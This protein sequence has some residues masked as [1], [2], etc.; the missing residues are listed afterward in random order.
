MIPIPRLLAA[1]LL[2]LLVAA[3][4]HAQ[5]TTPFD[6]ERE[7][8]RIA[9]STALW[10]GF[11][12][13]AI[14]L[15]VYDGERTLFFR[16]PSPP[17]GSVP[18]P[19]TDAVALSSRHPAVTA[20]SS[21]EIGGVVTATLLADGPRAAGGATAL[22]ATALH[23]AFHVF[24]RRRHPS[25]IANEGDL[26]LYP[27]DDPVPLAERRL[28]S[29]ALA[30]ALGAGDGAVAACWAREALAHRAARFAAMDSAFARYDRASELNEGL[31]AWI[32]LRAE[33][34]ATVAIPAAELPAA[35]V[36]DRAY[37][38]GP[39]LAFLLAR[40]EPAWRDSLEAD[41]RRSLDGMLAE[42]LARLSARRPCG[43]ATSEVAEI[44]RVADADARAVTDERGARRAAFD[45][46]PGPRLV[47]EAAQGR[48]LWPQ[49][50]DPLNVSRVEGGLLHTRFL[51]L[52]NA[53]G[54]LRALDEGSADV[55]ALTEAAGAHPLF[56]GVRRV[57]V[58]GCGPLAVGR[59][60]TAVT[61]RGAG[62]TLRF[63][64]AE[65]T[66][67]GGNVVVRVGAGP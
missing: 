54:T 3:R 32:Q 48:P 61:V 29:A 2:L 60:G 31:A 58:A 6:V 17:A 65:V 30:R 38:V 21:A 51:A 55:D 14:P 9:G 33:G 22:A 66:E 5:A 37:L 1:S 34:R 41:D 44:R 59:E 26:F 64:G 27:V 13:L 20:N 18:V 57:T 50:F 15:A 24:Q 47:V 23:E 10:P 35:A 39:A 43:F 49:G 4:A 53:A 28:E 16:H 25:W 63:D 62:C 40:F 36:R 46:R 67:E 12:P 11:A 45:A 19:G 7:V 56:D 52:G 8:R 42:A